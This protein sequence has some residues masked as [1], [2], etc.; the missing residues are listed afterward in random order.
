MPQ[1][2]NDIIKGTIS[3]ANSVSLS[4]TDFSDFNKNVAYAL[5]SVRVTVATTRIAD[6][7]IM[8]LNSAARNVVLKTVPLTLCNSQRTVWF[9]YPPGMYRSGSE[10]AQAMVEIDNCAID[11]SD[12]QTKDAVIVYSCMVSLREAGSVF[13]PEVDP[14]HV[15]LKHGTPRSLD[16]MV[17]T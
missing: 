10:L 3:V 15:K 5:S 1:A 6:V 11:Q 2:R 16:S 8:F 12:A 9:R 7:N 17:L 4:I 14:P 13:I